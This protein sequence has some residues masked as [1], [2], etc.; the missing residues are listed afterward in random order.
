MEGVKL[1]LMRFR[2]AEIIQRRFLSR[3]SL[4]PYE[5]ASARPKARVIR[6]GC[7]TYS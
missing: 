5:A 6:L 7:S 1:I 3:V 2:V 4:H